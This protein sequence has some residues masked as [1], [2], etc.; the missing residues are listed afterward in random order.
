MQFGGRHSSRGRGLFGLGAKPNAYMLMY[1]RRD[2]LEAN[3]QLAESAD[4][5]PADV[6]A[7]FERALKQGGEGV[8]P[9]AFVPEDADLERLFG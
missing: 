7:A 5:L 9:A 2:L 8:A 6:Q 1:V 4:L 3:G